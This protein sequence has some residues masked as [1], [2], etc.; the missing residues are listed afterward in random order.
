MTSRW[1]RPALALAV[2]LGI[3]I[4]AIMSAGSRA[5]PLRGSIVFASATRAP[6]CH[7]QE[8]FCPER[9]YVVGPHGGR[10]DSVDARAG[11]SPHWSADGR[12]L[13]FSAVCGTRKRGRCVTVRRDGEQRRLTNGRTDFVQGWSPDGK[14][15][16]FVRRFPGPGY[17]SWLY[18]VPSAGGAPVRVGSGRFVSTAG[19]SPDGSRLV[20]SM[21]KAVVAGSVVEPLYVTNAEGKVL[22]RLT[23]G[24]FRDEEPAWS[25]D[26][27]WIAFRRLGVG[28]A[29]VVGL[30][31]QQDI[32][33]RGIYL[34]RPD[35]SGLHRLE[36]GDDDAPSWSLDSRHLVVSH[37][38]PEGG[39]TLRIVRVGVSF[40]GGPVAVRH[41]T[42]PGDID[43]S[44]AWRPA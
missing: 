6:G 34:V 29:H 13:A 35:G 4:A 42:T 7:R 31:V 32:V 16:L 9:L 37:F 15:I 14:R 12:A 1:A 5:E 22:R 38:E 3:S 33:N 20:V 25:P 19:W 27:R 28:K 43:M 2:L 8:V 18:A 30:G 36:P 40:L 41:V 10:V 24:H 21:A 26:G 23:H 11:S 17:E 39:L 44:P